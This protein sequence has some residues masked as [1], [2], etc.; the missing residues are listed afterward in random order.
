[1][2]HRNPSYRD[3]EAI[4]PYNFVSLPA[5]PIQAKKPLDHDIYAHRDDDGAEVYSGS[6]ECALTTASPIYIRGMLTESDF[7]AEKEAKEDPAFFSLDGGTTPRIPGS[8]LRGLFRA[9]IEI[10]AGAR[11]HGVGAAR[12]VYRAVDTTSLGDQYRKRI[13]EET[14]KNWF[15]PRVKG[16]YIRRATD[17]SWRLQP[18]REIKGATWCR[19]SH[20]ALY[21]LGD[22]SQLPAWPPVSVAEAAGIKPGS[23]ERGARTLYIEPGANGFQEVRG[24]SIHI[25]FARAKQAST[26]PGPGLEAT[27]LL[28]SGDINKKGSEAII[29]PPDTSVKEDHWLR[30]DS[31]DENGEGIK[32]SRVY[33]DQMTPWQTDNLG[34][35][36]VLQ[37]MHPVFYLA[38]N[39]RLTFFGHT[40]MLRL[41]YKLGIRDHIPEPFRPESAGPNDYDLA[42]ALFGTVAK[43]RARAGQVTFSDGGFAG[44]LADPFEREIKPKVLSAPKPTTFQH[45]LQQEQPDLKLALSNYDHEAASLRGRKLY[46]HKGNV[47]IGDVEETDESKLRH[48]TQYT[49]IRAVKSGATFAF[50]IHFDNLR[51]AELGALAW[52]LEQAQNPQLRLSVGMVKPHGMGAIGITSVLILVDRR[53]RY[54]HL[55]GGGTFDTGERVD[56]GAVRDRAIAAFKTLAGGSEAGFD[57][58]RHIQELLTMLSWPGPSRDKTRY[59]EIERP[60]RNARRS[61]R[62]EYAD[63]P[64]LPGPEFVLFPTYRGDIAPPPP[65]R[66]EEEPLRS[67]PWIANSAR[68]PSAKQILA[69]VPE[70]RENV[71]EEAKNLERHLSRQDV[72]R[73]GE[74]YEATIT[75]IAGKEYE[76]SMGAGIRTPGKLP[77]DEKPGLSVGSLVKVRVKRIA[78]SGAAVLT[79]R[80]VK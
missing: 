25:H 64:V 68:E 49:R 2:K 65:R 13:M 6:F 70:V 15:M 76:C 43:G 59:M 54:T 12:P 28:K 22:F 3:R 66:P 51:P 39:G 62:N 8:S 14:Q 10:A 45:Y 52:I 75:G 48:E 72:A 19:I 67:P 38:E 5:Q 40:L 9:L 35:K 1:M 7:A 41:P 36:G 73:E 17:G 20:E 44:N 4:A 71:S 27:A 57:S 77:R 34:K 18:A 46:W 56:D 47:G 32:L 30:L 58:A 26:Q 50:R 74:E 37:D 23:I 60:D 42:E 63:R 29:Y 31:E 16:G 61:K 11:M 69:P 80:G 21:S 53:T 55:L 33:E 24:G 79:V 78:G